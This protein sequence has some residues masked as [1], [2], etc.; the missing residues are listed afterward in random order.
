MGLLFNFQMGIPQAVVATKTKRRRGR[1]K[2]S[3]KEIVVMPI[4]YSHLFNWWCITAVG[5]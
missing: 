2:E 5:G 3:S 1:K 4:Y